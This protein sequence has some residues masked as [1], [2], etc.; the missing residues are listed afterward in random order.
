VAELG[1]G[2]YVKAAFKVPYNVILLVG[3]LLGGI[4]SLHPAI[5]WP[6]VAAG[7][8]LYLA[9]MSTLPRFQAVVRAMHDARRAG[10]AGDLV[11]QLIGRLNSSRVQRFEQVRRRCLDLQRSLASEEQSAADGILEVQQVQGVNKLLWVFLRT[12]MQEQTLAGFCTTMPRKELEETMR[13]IEAALAQ[14]NL[15]EAMKEA[16]QENLQ[17]LRLRLENLRRAEENLEAISVRLVRVENSIMLIQEQALTRRDPA[18]V[19]SEVKSVTEGLQSVEEMM[20]SMDFPQADAVSSDVTPDLLR[21][22]D[23]SREAQKS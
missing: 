19:E 21:L 1:I 23:S 22:A 14:P 18:F 13:K 6:F 7:E 8:I 2:D 15:T 3:G 12:L 16:H 20:R 11:P 9:T 17:V 4:V 10:A 5:V